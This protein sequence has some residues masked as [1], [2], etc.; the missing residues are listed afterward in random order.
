[1]FP[2]APTNVIDEAWPVSML[3]HL[4]GSDTTPTIQ[5]ETLAPARHAFRMDSSSNPHCATK[6]KKKT[7]KFTHLNGGSGSNMM[8]VIKH[9]PR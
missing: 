1:M 4:E 8:L 3:D 6:G 9:M 2:S 5:G 7:Q